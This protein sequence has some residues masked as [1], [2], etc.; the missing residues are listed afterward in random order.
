LNTATM[1]MGSASQGNTII[2]DLLGRNAQVLCPH[3]TLHGLRHAFATV[4]L[5]AGVDLKT[6]S[7]MLGHST[8]AI[9]ADIYSHVP[10]KVQQAA[11][12]AVGQLVTRRP[13]ST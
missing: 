5:T 4:S 2:L 8:I 9:T 3:L 7:E 12:E 11:A 10:P 13:P 6:T 1:V